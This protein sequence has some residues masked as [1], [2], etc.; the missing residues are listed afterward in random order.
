MF[1]D[2]SGEQRVAGAIAYAIDDNQTTAWTCDLDPGRS[3][4]PHLAV[5][6][7]E[8]RLDARAGVRFTFKLA[9][10]HGGWNSDDN[11]NYNRGCLRCSVTGGDGARAADGAVAPRILWKTAQKLLTQLSRAATT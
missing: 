2:G 4:V 7:L 11:Q 5:F 10:Y 6:L 3:N 1:D 8:K 9:L